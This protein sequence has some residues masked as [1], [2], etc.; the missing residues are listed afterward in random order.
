[1]DDWDL[2]APQGKKNGPPGDGTPRKPAKPAGAQPADA[3]SVVA[4]TAATPAPAADAASAL[5]KTAAPPAPAVYA[6]G[7]SPSPAERRRSKRVRLLPLVAGAIVLLIIG[8]VVGFLIARSQS[9][10]NADELAQIQQRLGAAEKGLSESEDRNWSYYRENEAL[11]TQIV[12]LQKGSSGEPGPTTSTTVPGG[13]ATY[14]DGIYMV[15]EQI[16]PGDYDGVVTGAAGYWARLRGT[17]GLIG[18]IV[19]NAL[20]KGPFVLSVNSSD[21]AV[22]LRGVKITSR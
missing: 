16:A 15:G 8:A 7:D 20:V 2:E 13:P 1:M 22:E 6:G 18:E 11:K 10:A 19:A 21:V 3:A 14:T 12:E 5:A 9:G 17:D 4:K